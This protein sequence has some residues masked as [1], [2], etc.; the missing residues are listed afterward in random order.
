VQHF[1]CYDWLVATIVTRKTKTG[2]TRYLVQIRR[3]GCPPINRTFSRKETARSWAAEVETELERGRL[4]ERLQG[5]E[6]TL[7][8][9]IDRYEEEVLPGAMKSHELRRDKRAHLKFWSDAL[10]RATPLAQVTPA[11]ISE[12]R[13]RLLRRRICGATTNR[14]LTALSSVLSVAA[15]EWE[16][17]ESNPCRRVKRAKESP[18]RLRI[19]SEEERDQLL[20][21]TK[22]SSNRRLYPLTLFALATGARQGELLGLRWEDVDVVN[23]RATL[24]DTKNSETRTIRFPGISG[25]V[26]R[27][28]AKVQSIGGYVFGVSKKRPAFPRKAW[29]DAVEA[30]ELEGVV[31]HTLRH[32][33]ASYM[34]MSGASLIELKEFM[35]HRSL[36]QVQ[37][38]AHL[39]RAHS[40]ALQE[41]MV[42]DF[43]G[44]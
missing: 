29:A 19:L 31:F 30:A 12:A 7:G 32:T 27:E 34:A 38:Y 18:G 44:Q 33:A 8:E 40:E 11:R 1:F 20:E 9:A 16:W 25:T 35:G 15:G 5:A 26:L 37:R 42:G 10:G 28:L 17:I 21:A 6:R 3:K 2:K 13:S 23:L 36:S 22:A 43:L 39:T 14:Y 4:L 41:Q 24:H